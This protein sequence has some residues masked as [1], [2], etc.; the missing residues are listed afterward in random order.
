MM[1]GTNTLTGITKIPIMINGYE[2]YKVTD[3]V[4]KMGEPKNFDDWQKYVYYR[5]STR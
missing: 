1:R 3:E 4:R 5:V 2:W